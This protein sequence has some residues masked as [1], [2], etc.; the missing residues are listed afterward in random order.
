MINDAFT[1]EAVPDARVLAIAPL[2]RLDVTVPLEPVTDKEVLPFEAE[3]DGREDVVMADPRE[4]S[5][6][7]EEMVEV[8]VPFEVPLIV[9]TIDVEGDNPDGDVDDD[10][11]T[12]DD[13]DK[14]DVDRDGETAVPE[15]GENPD[16]FDV[17]CRDA[18]EDKVCE[19]GENVLVELLATSTGL[20]APADRLTAMVAVCGASVAVFAEA[21]EARVDASAEVCEAIIEPASAVCEASAEVAARVCDAVEVED[22]PVPTGSCRRS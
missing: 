5:D 2:D 14:D 19:A 15:L 18:E 12:E 11:D 16:V 8:P 13:N 21:C 6:E 17:V 10:G 20:E 3:A 22:S 1:D 9:G 7:A 4:V